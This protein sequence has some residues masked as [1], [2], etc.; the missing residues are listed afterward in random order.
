MDLTKYFSLIEK[1][2]LIVLLVATLASIGQIIGNIIAIKEVNL[3]DILLLFIFLEVIGMIKE[4]YVDSKI[5]IS[6]PI[7]SAITALARLIILQRK[8]Y[9]PE[10]L[11][12]EA[13]AIFILSVS[14]LAL[15]ARKIAFFKPDSDK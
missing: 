15:R 7:F 4:Y 9:D 1:I 5:A 10:I 14:I 8:D 3:A 12:Y 6:H 2:L 11:L 13:G